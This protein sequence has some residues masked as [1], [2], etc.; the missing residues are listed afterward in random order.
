VQK[1]D[2]GLA[3]TTM[4]HKKLQ[5]IQD[6]LER[7]RS[8]LQQQIKS[9]KLSIP[10]NYNKIFCVG[11]NKTGTEST[12]AALIELGFHFAPQLP[13]E[14]M[15]K[16]WAERRFE[17]LINFC[18]DYQCFKDI[19]FS[20][21]YTF[22][23]LD[24]HYPNSKFI[25][26]IRDNSEVWFESI[27]RFHGQLFSQGQTPSWEDLE[28]ASYVYKSWMAEAN[29]YIFQADEY[30]LYAQS[31]YIE[32]YEFHNQMVRE[33]FRYRSDALLVIN[34]ASEGSYD[35]LCKFLDVSPVRTK[36]PHLNK[37]Q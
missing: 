9:L 12:K 13:G 2:R 7:S 8:F 10:F 1:R 27:K 26:T 22:Q 21:P 37:S 11:M 30:G 14:R 25:L 19:P 32:V 15:L 24:T 3:T 34:T 23:I 29:K 33:Y 18:Y 6:D 35:Q 20:W 31:R 17:K 36:F 4:E 5:Y 28:S 16:E